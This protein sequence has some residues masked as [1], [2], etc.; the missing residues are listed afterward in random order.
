MNLTTKRRAALAVLALA[1]LVSSG[2]L[3]GARKAYYAS[4]YLG[5]AFGPAV[6]GPNDNQTT[7]ILIGLL[8]PAVQN[9]LKS[10]F[11]LQVLNAKGLIDIPV[12]VKSIRRNAPFSVHVKYDEANQSY[13]IIVKN[14]LT[15]QTYLAKSNTDDITIRVLPAVQLDGVV[16]APISSSATV[17]G[18]NKVTMGDGS[19]L[20]L[21]FEYTL[22]AVGIQDDGL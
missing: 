1:T 14:Q 4:D 3:M 7:G 10:P 8:L 15:G 9:E 6:I 16:L 12:P 17:Q 2:I 13:L 21:P 19:V 5:V 11:H 18:V 22:G 20:P